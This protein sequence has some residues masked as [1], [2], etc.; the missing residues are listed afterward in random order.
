M[1]GEYM[2][3]PMASKGEYLGDRLLGEIFGEI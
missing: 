1:L 3:I 2:Q